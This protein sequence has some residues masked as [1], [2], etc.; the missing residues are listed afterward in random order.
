MRLDAVILEDPMKLMIVDN[1]PT[2]R[3]VIRGIVARP[4]DQV[5]ECSDGDEVIPAFRA[6]SADWVLM[7]V[8]MGRMSGMQATRELKYTFPDAH[9]AILTN[10]GS[11]EFREEA[12]SAGAEKYFLK[13]NLPVIRKELEAP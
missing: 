5:V 1:D 3:E 9:V 4:E 13:D 8:Q 2:M 6:F 7:D 10:Y 11:I 12:A